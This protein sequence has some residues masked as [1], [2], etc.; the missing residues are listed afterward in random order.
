VLFAPDHGGDAPDAAGN[1]S[2]SAVTRIAAALKSVGRGSDAIGR[3]GPSAFAVVALDTDA[4]QARHLA[5]RLRRAIFAT[6]HAA[7]EPTPPFRLHA[8]Y[9]G[10]P[11]FQAASID[12]VDLMLRATAALRHARTDPGGEW[13]QLF[14]DDDGTTSAS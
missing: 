4:T 10:V 3:L 14:H 12:P 1:G 5:E 13:I 7:A 2:P 9:H 6:P 8:G 11:N